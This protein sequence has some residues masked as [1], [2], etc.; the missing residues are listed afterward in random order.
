MKHMN[1]A[2]GY[3]SIF[4][5]NLELIVASWLTI[6]KCERFIYIDVNLFSSLN[7]VIRDWSQVCKRTER[8]KCH[9]ITILR[10]V[11]ATLAKY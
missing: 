3:T 9:V 6:Y 5:Y 2:C 10:R 1:M 4:H 11:Y 8:M 7:I